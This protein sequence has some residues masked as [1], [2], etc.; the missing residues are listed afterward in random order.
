L[1]GEVSVDAPEKG[2]FAGCVL[3][4]GETAEST[5]DPILVETLARIGQS[6]YIGFGSGESKR[7]SRLVG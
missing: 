6:A 3:T 2:N 5:V 7:K 4:G 1:V